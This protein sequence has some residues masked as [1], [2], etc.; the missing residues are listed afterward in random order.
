[1]KRVLVTGAGGQLG[2]AIFR[3]HKRYPE[4]QFHFT[5]R[6]DLDITESEAVAAFCEKHDINTLINCAAY[7]KV[8]QAES[9]R[10]AAYAINAEA[11]KDLAEVCAKRNAL[12]LH[13]STDFVFDGLQSS[14]YMEGDETW[15]LGVYGSSKLEGEYM[16]LKHNP[17]TIIV[18]SSW[19]YGET[20]HNFLRTM[21]KLTKERD[22][23]NVVFD[24][25]GTPTYTGD[26]AAALLHIAADPALEGK[27][28]IYHYSNEGVASWYDFA[29]AI[30]GEA[31]HSCDIRP[32]RTA[33]YPTPATR[34]SYSVLDKAKIKAAFGLEVPYWRDSLRKCMEKIK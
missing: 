28:G 26:L 18:R 12:L 23:L 3:L 20:G 24:Q 7:T 19:V 30:A 13:L 10:A 6:E 25:A 27:Y 21:L 32:I 8:D 1:V 16:A 14:P 31:G 15:P 5:G 9:E 4:W 17:R 22:T 29:K 34:P 33:Q 11:V 2:Q